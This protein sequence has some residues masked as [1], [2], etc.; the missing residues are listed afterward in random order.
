V[1]ARIALRNRCPDILPRQPWLER[2]R[3]PRQYL[4]VDEEQ[5]A[6][7]QAAG[8]PVAGAIVAPADFEDA[9]REHFAPVY[10]F[11]ARRVGTAL[12]EDLA[13]EA[14]ATAYRRRASYEPSRGSLRPWLYGIAANVVRGHWREEQ[15]LL[16]LDARLAPAGPEPASAG[17]FADAAD[18]RVIAASLAPRIAGAL[19]ALNREQRDVLLLHAWAELSHEEIAAALGIAQGTARSRLSRA[20]AALRV[21]LK[22]YAR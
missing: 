14:F 19:A 16:E 21:L 7:G 8:R 18:E 6:G 22:D 12:A 3:P 2:I 15:Q 20:R 4:C 9:F 11:I 10:R 17:P 5:A 13:A 1:K